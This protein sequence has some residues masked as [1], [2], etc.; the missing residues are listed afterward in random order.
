MSVDVFA[1][2]LV[3]LLSVVAASVLSLDEVEVSVL[4]LSPVSDAKSSEVIVVVSESVE[5]LELESV[6]VEDESVEDESVEDESV[7]VVVDSFSG[8]RPSISIE[9]TPTSAGVT[10]KLSRHAT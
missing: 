6:L 1:L 3:A 5:V 2:S 8:V 9:E 4:A 10:T 7:E